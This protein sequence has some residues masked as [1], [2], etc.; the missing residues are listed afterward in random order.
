MLREEKYG[1]IKIHNEKQRRHKT[2]FSN[3]LIS[4]KDVDILSAICLS[5]V[6]CVSFDSEHVRRKGYYLLI[7]LKRQLFIK[8]LQ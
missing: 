7:S 1:I 3:Q 5:P 2:P 8:G 6:S 4:K